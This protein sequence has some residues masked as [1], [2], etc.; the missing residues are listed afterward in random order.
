MTF[1]TYTVF[2]ITIN[3]NN[4]KAIKFKESEYYSTTLQ[5]GVY[6]VDNKPVSLDKTENVQVLD[7]N[8]VKP[9]TRKPVVCRYEDA[10]GNVLSVDDYGKATSELLYR[11]T[12]DEYN[13]RTWAS[14]DD[15]FNYKKFIQR[16][17]AIYRDIE[18]IGDPYSFEIVE[19]TIDTGNKFIS[20]DY[21]N[22]GTDPL[23][24]SYNRPA[25][26]H[27]IV[28]SKFTQLGM[29]FGGEIAYQET[30]RKKVWGNS[31]HSGIRYVTAFNTYVFNDAW[32]VKYS[33][34]GTLEQVLA[35]YNSD[36]K[37]LES[38]IELRYKEHFGVVDDSKFDF[39]LLQEKLR[40]ALSRMKSVEPKQK[41]YDDLRVAKE[42]INESIKMIQEAHVEPK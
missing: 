35:K 12:H 22:G 7:I 18:S 17:N 37:E 4:M 21:I 28:R 2:Y 11:S 13:S 5:R 19:S 32:D 38:I 33:P 29:V 20:S 8:N 10:D 15:E 39:K 40:M 34:R 14:L 41:S 36:K 27:E 1:G 6:V 42:R 16:W 25:A 23:L 3:T 26:V 9:I 31:T 24:F 30:N